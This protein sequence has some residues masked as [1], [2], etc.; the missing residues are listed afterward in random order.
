MVLYREKRAR[1]R[2]GAGE[3]DFSPASNPGWANRGHTN[4]VA[5]IRRHG[6]VFG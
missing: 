1:Q 4:W 5:P 2:E 6:I 3:V